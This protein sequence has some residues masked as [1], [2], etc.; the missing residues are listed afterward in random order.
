[1][2]T[3]QEFIQEIRQHQKILHKLC[4][5]Y[6]DTDEDR[7]DLFQ[8]ILLS[9]WKSNGNFRRDSKF[10]TWL[11]QIGL[12]TGISFLRREKRRP[13][14]EPFDLV[15]MGQVADLTDDTTAE[16]F[17]ALY[18]AI[19]SLPNVDKAIV[20]LYMDDYDYATIGQLVGITPAYV[21]VKMGRIK[22]QLRQKMPER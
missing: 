14:S 12:N 8:E 16:Q 10:S 21:A 3:E 2:L 13:R 7:K 15:T 11:Y 17:T 4:Y 22:E 1:M 19:S 6:A 20:L 18:K 9:A 5:L